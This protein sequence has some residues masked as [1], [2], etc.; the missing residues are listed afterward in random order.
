MQKSNKKT[1]II[2]FIIIAAAGTISHFIYEWSGDNTLIGAFF[3]VNESSWE[4]L[5]LLF[6]PAMIYSIVLYMRNKNE[7]GK[8]LLASALGTI[9]G[10]LAILVFFYTYTGIIGTNFLI[11]DIISF[12][13]GVLAFF[14]HTNA[15]ELRLNCTEKYSCTLG[16]L[17]F[18]SLTLLFIIFTFNPPRIALFLDPLAQTYGI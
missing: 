10:M 16:A 17:I 14:K 11:M 9:T 7:N 5:K 18:L 6:L 3:P 4:H 1:N 15:Y 13:F 2:G 8:F 12:F